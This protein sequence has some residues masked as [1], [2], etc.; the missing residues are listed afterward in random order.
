LE[1]ELRRRIEAGDFIDRFPT[2]RELMEIYGVSR[3]TARHAVAQLGAGGLL[4]RSRGIGSSVDA[5]TLERSLG[6]LYS[7]FQVVEESGLPQRSEVRHLG[8]VVDHS[9]A[10]RLGID[11]TSELVHLD[12]LRYAGDVPLAIDRT[13]LPASVA[14]PLLRVDFTRTSLY[15]ELDR[16]IG[17]RPS[18]G[19]E[20]IHPAIPTNEERTALRLEAD[21]AVFSIERLGLH[22]DEPLEWRIT[23]TRGDRF[24]F[25]ADWS[26]GQRTD[27]RFQMLDS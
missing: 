25:L 22:D 1:G 4:R 15:D 9:V 24:A 5:R 19:W 7:L 2:D 14:R 6:A 21:Q 3:H 18:E 13:W 10:A 26:T 11:P 23:T 17:R 16:L 8:L 12:R 27:L 20:R